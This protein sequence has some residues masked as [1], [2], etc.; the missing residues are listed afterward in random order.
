MSHQ[1]QG[2]DSGSREHHQEL[3]RALVWLTQGADFAGVQ[4]RDDCRWSIRGLVMTA[5]LWA[6][7]GESTLGARFEQAKKIGRRMLSAKDVPTSSYQAFTKLLR[8]WTEPLLAALS[9]VFRGKMAAVFHS[10]WRLGEFVPFGVDGSRFSLPRTKSNEEYFSSST[11]KRKGTQKKKRSRSQQSANAREK[12]ANN[13]QMWVTTLWHLGIGLPWSWRRGPSSSSERDHLSEMLGDLGDFMALIVADAGFY[14]Y[15]LWSQI[16][17]NH[18]FLIRVGSNVKLLSQLGFAKERNGLVY[19]WPDHAAKKS[20][21]PLV[22]RLIVIHNGKHPVYL[23]T[24]VLDKKKLSDRD[25]VKAYSMRWGIELYYRHVKQTFDRTKLRSHSSE[26]ALLEADWSLLGLW[27]MT[28]H[29]QFLLQSQRQDPQRLSV[30]TMLRAYRATMNE[31]RCV[32]EKGEDLRS[33]V[34]RSL[35]DTYQRKCKTSRNYPRKK[36][37]KTAGPP[38]ITV[39][40]RAQVKQARQMKRELEKGLTA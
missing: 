5:I 37:E 15:D 14:G 24:S 7:S 10:R 35:C 28:I 9:R 6:W 1:A 22:L 19:C 3:R 27:A 30:A 20:Q 36:Q 32:P 31:Y 8:K 25:A 34:R 18:H 16:T 17:Q 39:A 26:H 33:L 40:T 23:V 2:S 38:H 4:F 11:K 12:K 13:P 29:A 21:L